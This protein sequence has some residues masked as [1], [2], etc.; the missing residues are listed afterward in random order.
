MWFVTSAS[1]KVPQPSAFPAGAQPLA[2]RRRGAPHAS[3]ER[4]VV[5]AT[6]YGTGTRLSTISSATSGCAAAAAPACAYAGRGARYQHSCARIS[7]LVPSTPASRFL[8]T[9]SI[10]PPL[11][12]RDWL[13][14]RARRLSA[15]MFGSRG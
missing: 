9:S 10:V 14:V 1:W 11:S 4:S 3:G 2:R 8:I 13:G 7:H 6:S 12:M 5:P 15:V